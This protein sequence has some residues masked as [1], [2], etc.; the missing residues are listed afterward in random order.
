MSKLVYIDDIEFDKFND[1]LIFELKWSDKRST[2]SPRK[3][4][5]HAIKRY[6]HGLP[7]TRTEFASFIASEKIKG[8]KNSTVNRKIGYGIALAK[9]MRI[10]EFDNI[11]YFPEHRRKTKDVLSWEEMDMIATVKPE[12]PR[13]INGDEINY[14][15]YCLIR[16]LSETGCRIG[17]ALD[18]KWEDIDGTVLSFADTKNGETRNVV[19]TKQLSEEF[20]QLPVLSTRVFNNTS[21]SGACFQIKKRAK[22]AGVIKKTSIS[23]HLFRHSVITNL[24]M[25]GA[26]VKVVMDLVGHK[27]MDTTAGYINNTL[28]DMENM[29][30]Q[31]SG[32]WGQ[33]MTV[34]VFKN[35]ALEAVSKLLT[36][37]T[38][39]VKMEEDSE[40]LYIKV[41]KD[42]FILP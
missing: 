24:V 6:F 7:Y 42:V 16:L 3:Y 18:L 36:W 19:I 31:Y 2:L 28:E 26:P 15:Y 23:P 37:H 13:N 33:T 9:F 17:E 32:L 1:F 10:K 20:R 30:Y 35:K 11:T 4:C 34:N 5:F 14:R 27:R 41:P 39:K 38:N 40:F 22:L 29:L 25:S 8:H 12:Y 21:T